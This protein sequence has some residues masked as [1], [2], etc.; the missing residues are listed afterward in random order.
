M[1]FR[2]S[3]GFE[4]KPVKGEAFFSRLREVVRVRGIIFHKTS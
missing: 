1:P 2:A 3:G 4:A